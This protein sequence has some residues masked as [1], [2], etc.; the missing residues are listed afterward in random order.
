MFAPFVYIGAVILGGLLRPGY[1]H[2]AHAI[3]ELIATGAPNTALLNPLFTLYNILLATF[4]SGLLRT[5]KTYPGERGT[6]SGCWGALA[7]VIVGILGVLMNVFFPHKN[8]ARVRIPFGI[9][10]LP[11]SLSLQT[12]RPWHPHGDP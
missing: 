12:P 4:G 8:H 1:S 3:S 7:L 9:A 2:I 10:P 5:V 11:A 6:H